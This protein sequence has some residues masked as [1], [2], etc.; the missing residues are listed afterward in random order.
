[1]NPP[2]RSGWTQLGLSPVQDKKIVLIRGILNYY[3]PTLLNKSMSQGKEVHN[4]V[5]VV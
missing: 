3:A 4:S 5:V 2:M 1:M